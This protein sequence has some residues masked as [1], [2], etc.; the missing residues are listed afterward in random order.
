MGVP[1]NTVLETKGGWSLPLFLALLWGQL[2]FALSPTWLEIP[3]Y[4]YA[5]VAAPLLSLLL[6]QAWKE[7]ITVKDPPSSSSK[8]P[9]LAVVLFLIVTPLIVL[10]PLQQVDQFWRLPLWLHAFLVLSATFLTIVWALGWRRSRNFL[11]LSLFVVLLVPLPS[12]LEAVITGNL[13]RLVSGGVGGLLPWMGYPIDRLGN[14]MLVKG[15]ILDVAEGCSGLRSFQAAFMAGVIL[16]EFYQH[17]LIRRI[18][19]LLTAIG[20]A[21]MG[22]GVRIYYLTTVAYNQGPE[23]E[24][25]VHGTAGMI[26]TT[27]IFTFIGLVAWWLSR[28]ETSVKKRTVR[29]EATL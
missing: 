23:A 6:F 10:R 5:L 24:A 28:G 15:T 11:R 2:F 8:N 1:Q 14:A 19:L 18:L 25:R 4:Q 12:A 7:A 9:I 13:T 21:M 22:N 29:R 3:S 20:L 16:G 27:L 17:T 26:V